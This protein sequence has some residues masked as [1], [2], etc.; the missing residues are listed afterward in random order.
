M[1]N[2]LDT[3]EY[4]PKIGDVIDD[5]TVLEEIGEGGKSH[6]YRVENRPLEINRVIKFLKKPESVDK[7]RFVTE[8]RINANLNH[9]NIIHC[10][11]FGYYKDK[12]PY[13]EMEFVD[14]FDLDYLI[15]RNDTI[16]ATVA[17]AI[18]QY[19][20]DALDLLH[21]CKYTLYGEDRDGIVHRD[22]K[23]ANILISKHGDV[24]LADF[25]IAK[26]TELSIHTTEMRIIGTIFYL[27]PEQINMDDIDFLSDIYSLGCVIYEMITGVKTFKYKSITA[28]V[29][30]KRS[31]NYD[32]SRLNNIP[33][34]LKN[35][36]IKCL[37]PNKSDRYESVKDLQNALKQFLQNED[38][39]DLKSTIFDFIK[40]P[41][42]FLSLEVIKN[43]KNRTKS[44]VVKVS[45]IVGIISVAIITSA[46]FFNNTKNI[47]KKTITKISKSTSKT[48]KRE[49]VK[50]NRISNE[51]T[52]KDIKKSNLKNSKRHQNIPNR[53]L[54]RSDKD[55]L[56]YLN[57][58][59]EANKLEQL[60]EEI[61]NR[62][63]NTDGYFFYILGKNELKKNSPQKALSNFM[64]SLTLP[65]FKKELHFL[66]NYQMVKAK[67]AIFKAQ[68]NTQNRTRLEKATYQFLENFSYK[69]SSS[70]YKDIFLNKK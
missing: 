69:K 42:T 3:D 47:Q 48:E 70:E 61:S 28:V 46:L 10:Y 51:N 59:E 32:K 9:P 12:Y 57:T 15:T 1:G 31:N 50:S 24:K 45:V 33:T 34:E 41:E 54:K 44:F 25:G 67:E 7:D 19:L 30:A 52:A 66:A 21:H 40:D 11:R 23:P 53:N 56:V 22:I 60:T 36:I 49:V 35:I 39:K 16:P 55:Y 14:G 4:I 20:C 13:M 29:E 5:Y 65:S 17:A 27:S 62:S 6:V 2:F 58:L 43:R 37:E 8:A 18:A 38:I 64:N 68:P 63:V 26:P